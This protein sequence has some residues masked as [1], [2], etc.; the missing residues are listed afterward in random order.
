MKR[1]KKNNRRLKGGSGSNKSPIRKSKPSP[2]RKSSPV[3]KRTVRFPNEDTHAIDIDPDS[4]VINVKPHPTKSGPSI[5]KKKKS[6]VPDGVLPRPYG[7]IFTGVNESPKYN[8]GR[9]TKTLKCKIT[10]K[11]ACDLENEKMR[12]SK[13]SKSKGG[14]KTLKKRK[15]K[16]N[17]K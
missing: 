2:V 5:L 8:L 17:K 1:T 11:K 6:K 9:Y 3:R 16:T 12:N 15:R 10:G 13:N 14:K 4:F 7:T